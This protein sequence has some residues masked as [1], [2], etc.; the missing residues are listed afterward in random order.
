MSAYLGLGLRVALV[1]I[2]DKGV[3]RN[4]TEIA[5][6]QNRTAVRYLDTGLPDPENPTETIKYAYRVIPALARPHELVCFQAVPQGVNIPANIET[7]EP[8]FK[9]Y[10]GPDQP[11]QQRRFFNWGLKRATD[12]GAEAVAFLDRTSGFSAGDLASAFD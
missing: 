4:A 6:V 3:I 1:L 10:Y 7:I 9:V 11:S 12:Y 8:S 5:F 2:H